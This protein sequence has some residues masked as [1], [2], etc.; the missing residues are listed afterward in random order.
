MAAIF[1]FICTEQ[2]HPDMD[3]QMEHFQVH[4]T[5]AFIE[6]ISRWTTFH[7]NTFKVVE[8]VLKGFHSQSTDLV[9]Y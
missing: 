7:S 8:Y 3:M 1:Q 9:I 4:T 2:L 5:L 6:I